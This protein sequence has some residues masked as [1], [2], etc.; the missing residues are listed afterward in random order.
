MSGILRA[1]LVLGIA[2][3]LGAGCDSGASEH[4]DAAGLQ[5]ARV[6]YG[7]ALGLQWVP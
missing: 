6:Q 3:M 2:A 7:L 4:C 5:L 1:G